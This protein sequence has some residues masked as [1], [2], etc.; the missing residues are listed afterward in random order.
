MGIELKDFR[1]RITP[2]TWCALEAEARATSS[3]Q[4]QLVR[5][6]LHAWAL[7]RIHAASVL[8][9]LLRAEGVV[10]EDAGSAGNAREKAA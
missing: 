1:G 9:R 10:G 6:I 2:E 5:D 8:P 3:D 4:Q 7:E